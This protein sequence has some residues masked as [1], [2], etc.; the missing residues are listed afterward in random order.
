MLTVNFETD[1]AVLGKLYAELKIDI[2]VSGSNFLLREDGKPIGLM[3][4]E[5]GDFVRI[6][7]FMLLKEHLNYENREFFLRAM[8]FKFSLNTYPLA[9][10][11][12]VEELKKFGFVFDG[13]RT[14][15]NSVDIN[16]HGECEGKK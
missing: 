6:T 16:L 14:V 10:D 8:M 11:G 12:D 15:I 9:A 13:E 4:V 2:P 7:H 5:I 3:R 1:C